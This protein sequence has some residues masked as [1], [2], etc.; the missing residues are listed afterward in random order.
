MVVTTD[1]GKL[2]VAVFYLLRGW[3][4]LDFPTSTRAHPS[5][6]VYVQR[7]SKAPPRGYYDAYFPM[8]VRWDVWNNVVVPIY[9]DETIQPDVPLNEFL[10][11]DAPQQADQLTRITTLISAKL[12]EQG[13]IPAST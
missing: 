3:G 13:Y 1:P 6:L 8:Q 4:N 10:V 9:E 12:V 7:S 2:A 5:W 11:G